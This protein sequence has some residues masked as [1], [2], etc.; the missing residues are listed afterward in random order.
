VNP[1]A[2][3][4]DSTGKLSAIQNAKFK[5]ATSVMTFTSATSN[6]VLVLATVAPTLP[7]SIIV[8]FLFLIAIAAGVFVVILRQKQK[9]NY[10]DYLRTKYYNL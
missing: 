10:D 6:S 9:L 8:T 1:L 3:S 4:S 5:A 7:W 2:Y